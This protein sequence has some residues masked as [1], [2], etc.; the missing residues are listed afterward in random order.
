MHPTIV[1]YLTI[2]FLWIQPGGKQ[3]IRGGGNGKVVQKSMT[4][5]NI[6]PILA[7][8]APILYE[9]SS[10]HDA[11]AYVE[12]S[13]VP[14]V[15]HDYQNPVSFLLTVR[16]EDRISALLEMIKPVPEYEVAFF[17]CDDIFSDAA[18]QNLCVYLWCTLR[19][20]GFEE[21]LWADRGEKRKL[22]EN[23]ESDIL[24][25]I[26][27][28]LGDILDHPTTPIAV[29]LWPGLEDDETNSASITITQDDVVQDKSTYQKLSA[30][31]PNLVNLC[32][33]MPFRSVSLFP[34]FDDV[35][36]LLRT[37]NPDEFNMRDDKAP[38]NFKKVNISSYTQDKIYVDGKAVSRD[39]FPGKKISY[40]RR[41]IK[42]LSIDVLGDR[43]KVWIDKNHEQCGPDKIVLKMSAQ[44]GPG[45]ES[46]I[47]I[48]TEEQFNNGR[49]TLDYLY[50]GI[51]DCT[52]LYSQCGDQFKKVY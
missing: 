32:P 10:N 38:N 26:S 16:S 8:I 23:V 15:P 14:D 12:S 5:E 49:P 42:A 22:E 34:A 1:C 3:K 27:V 2:F 29:I 25:H 33:T 17:K 13:L 46:E 18:M 51:S 11:K 41:T 50:K 37:K 21:D 30:S 52:I 31:V 28:D 48:R 20:F 43:A 36:K 19:N 45:K 40:I 39:E 9:S 47:I 6:A 24:N 44:P 7:D 35:L 4:G